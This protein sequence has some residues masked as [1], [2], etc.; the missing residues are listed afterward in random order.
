MGFGRPNF[1]DVGRPMFVGRPMWVGRPKV[2]VSVGSGRGLA[3]WSR[4]CRTSVGF[5]TSEVSDVRSPPDVQGICKLSVMG[6]LDVRCLSDVRHFGLL[7]SVG[8]P[9]SDAEL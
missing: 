2:V 3:I 6:I 8:R 7:K 9:T 5:R 1:A 4:R